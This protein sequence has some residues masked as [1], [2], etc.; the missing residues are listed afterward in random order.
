MRPHHRLL[1][2]ISGLSSLTSSLHHLVIGLIVC[3][4]TLTF[5]GS[6]LYW[7]LGEIQSIQFNSQISINV[8]AITNYTSTFSLLAK[9]TAPLTL[10]L[11]VRYVNSAPPRQVSKQKVGVIQQ[12]VGYS[13]NCSSSSHVWAFTTALVKLP[14]DLLLVGTRVLLYS[15]SVVALFLYPPVAYSRDTTTTTK[16]ISSAWLSLK[17]SWGNIVCGGV[18]EPRDNMNDSPRLSR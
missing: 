18:A 1:C 7:N 15:L 6:K 5:S 4:L 10:N 9:L 3:R 2:K 13:N 17:N 16:S 11:E 12:L 14:F 8:N